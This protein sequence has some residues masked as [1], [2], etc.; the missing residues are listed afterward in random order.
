MA[1]EIQQRLQAEYDAAKTDY[2]AASCDLDN[3][4][5]GAPDRWIALRRLDAAGRRQAAAATALDKRLKLE[6]GYDDD[7]HK[8]APSYAFGGRRRGA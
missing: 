5:R 6:R 8:R 7:T 4:P 3:T 2:A 1:S